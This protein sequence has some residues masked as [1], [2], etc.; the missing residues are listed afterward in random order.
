MPRSVGIVGALASRQ[1]STQSI[2]F[3]NAVEVGMIAAGKQFVDIALVGGVKDELIL[4]RTENPVQGD[5]QFDYPELGPRCPPF[6]EVVEISLSRISLAKASRESSSRALT[7]AGP[8]I[9]LRI[10]YCLGASHRIVYSRSMVDG[11]KR[12][13]QANE[14]SLSILLT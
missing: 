8:S 13:G 4:W 6:T 1:E 5:G 9:R 12:E 14:E 2:R 11:R 10:G 7:S 3:S